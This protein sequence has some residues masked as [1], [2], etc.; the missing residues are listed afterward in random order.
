[1]NN[2]IG[3]Q[4]V[5]QHHRSVQFTRQVLDDPAVIYCIWTEESAVDI[6]L[7]V[8][9]KKNIKLTFL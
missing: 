9:T 8:H 7:V 1:M 3:E 5:S 6:D 4:R 2:M